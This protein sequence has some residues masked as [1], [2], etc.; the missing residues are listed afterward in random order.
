MN[1]ARRRPQPFRHDGRFHG[2]QLSARALICLVALSLTLAGLSAGEQSRPK[3]KVTIQGDTK[4]ETVAVTLPIDPTP[5]IQIGMGQFESFGLTVDGK[6][7]TFS[8]QGGSVQT[9]VKI[10]NQVFNFGDPAQGKFV[11]LR[12]DLGKGPQGQRRIGNRSTWECRK[13]LVT[14]VLE[15]VPSRPGKN[16]VAG[17]RRLDVCRASYVLENKDSQPHEVGIRMGHDIYVVDNDGAQFSSPTVPNKVLNGYMLKGKEM[18]EYVKV[19]QRPDLKNPLYTSTFT[20]K[21]GSRI[22]APDQVSLTGLGACFGG[23]D[24]PAMASGDTA[25]G[26]F[27]NPKK[28][29][30]GGKREVGYAYGEGQAA[31]PDNEGKVGLAVAGS[32]EPN[33]QFTVTA[34]V[35]DPLPGQTL[36]LELPE[37]MERVEG[38]AMQPVPVAAEIGNSM[39]VWKGRVL[40]PG[41]YNLRVNS[42]TGA[43]LTRNVTIERQ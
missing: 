43:L 39:V 26:I 16:A 13:V 35:E 11:E 28:V 33:R 7:I 19:L 29:N 25:I 17:K 22:E 30:P 20:F 31:N 27:F 37:G 18:P 3:Y 5:H 14:Q 42:S 10:D 23:W 40:R 24:I 8:P 12:K 15:V 2:S 34:M 9:L 36:T 38:K 4:T 6:R 1:A 32:F 41:S 21:M